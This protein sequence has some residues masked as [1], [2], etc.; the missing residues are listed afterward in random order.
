MNNALNYH[1]TSDSIKQT[2]L[3]QFDPSVTRKVEDTVNC[4]E[5]NHTVVIGNDIGSA[6]E[7]L[8]EHITE[9]H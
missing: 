6:L 9:T 5:C 4:Y 3:W 2:T 7:R 1:T 8:N